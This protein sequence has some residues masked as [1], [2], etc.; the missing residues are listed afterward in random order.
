VSAASEAT[1]RLIGADEDRA[2][3]LE[4]ISIPDTEGMPLHATL[5]LEPSSADRPTITAPVTFTR[6]LTGSE[7]ASLLGS[8]P[9][10]VLDARLCCVVGT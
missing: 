4:I 3:D 8:D 10:D 1:Q 9:G 5:V 6:R 7:G 2:G